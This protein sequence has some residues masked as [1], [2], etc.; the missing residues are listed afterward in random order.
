MFLLCSL[1]FWFYTDEFF[2]WVYGYNTNILGT[3]SD[4]N[5]EAF[6]KTAK[7]R[8]IFSYLAMLIGVLSF[9]VSLIAI[10]KRRRIWGLEY[11]FL[12]LSGIS[13][14]IFILLFLGSGMIPT[15]GTI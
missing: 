9:V 14:I 4:L 13:I 7:A 5:R 8:Q 2:Y 12:I 10:K 6:A 11:I 3:A 1:I 15:G